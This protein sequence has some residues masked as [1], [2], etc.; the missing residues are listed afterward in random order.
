MGAAI[1][2]GLFLLL[3][4]GRCL[5]VPAKTAKPSPPSPSA[6]DGLDDLIR[7]AHSRCHLLT[8]T[9][10]ILMF[11]RQP[12]SDKAACSL[13]ISPDQAL[14]GL[15]HYFWVLVDKQFKPKWVLLYAKHTYGNS[16]DRFYLRLTLDG[17]LASVTLVHA[18]FEHGKWEA[19]VITPKTP[20]SPDAQRLAF[21]ELELWLRRT[22]LREEWRDGVFSNGE[23]IK[24][25]ADSHGP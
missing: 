8:L 4:C 21:Q 18:E 9:T 22:F 17:K 7:T 23:L 2:R 24:A 15:D 5:G 11:F 19:K 12:D 16:S 25:P 10:N 3:L 1:V 20:A 14:D 13:E 6:A